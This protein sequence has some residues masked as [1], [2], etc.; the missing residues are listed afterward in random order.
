MVFSSI[1][2]LFLFLPIVLVT[3][4]LLRKE[5]QN[6]FLLAVS[7]L[8]Y[9]WGE[10]WLLWIVLVSAGVNYVCGLLIAGSLLGEKVVFLEKGGKRSRYQKCCLYF[11][12]FANLGFLGY[13]K[14]ANFFAE[15]LREVFL[16]IG[17]STTFLAE[18]A[19]IA[20]P[21]GISFYTFQSMSYTIDVYRGDVK[22]SRNFVDFACY[23]AMFPQLVAGPI[24][25][26]RD[27]EAQLLRKSIKLSDLSYGVKR[28][29]YGLAKKVLLAN[30]LAQTVDGVF[31]L[32]P[33][34]LSIG[35]A[36]LGVFCYALQIYFDFSG[37]SDMAIGLGSMFGFHFLENF[38]YPYFAI[39]LQDFW[40]RWHISLSTW[41]RDYLYISLGGSRCSARRMYGN[42]LVTFLLCG[43][44]HGASW[45]FVLWGFGHGVFLI[46]ER[47]GLLSFLE[48]LPR[49]FRHT[50]VILLVLLGW[51]LFRSE[52]LEQAGD[53]YSVMFGFS[54][55]N[56]SPSLVGEFVGAK[57]FCV[58]FIGVVVAVPSYPFLREVCFAAFKIRGS[59]LTRSYDVASVAWGCLLFIF[60]A[61]SLAAG[62]YNPFIYF[63]F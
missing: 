34:E 12:I 13:F 25:R 43:L 38:N 45:N 48:R 51:V 30:V 29:I 8:F 39:S 32:S 3:Y 5:V 1:T 23:V 6:L 47:L 61:M 2:F 52:T 27:I 53:F 60:S 62:V 42:L 46:L 26:Y 17:M 4:H 37:Y 56:F 20:L 15:N 21:L 9:F 7:L 16:A 24:V 11:S 41:L 10:Q 35:I 54:S 50:Y 18:F 58:L 22:A 36:W 33:S 59:F 49:F 40:R 63:R 44:W 14:Y 57:L 19:E 31:A 55:A 28:F